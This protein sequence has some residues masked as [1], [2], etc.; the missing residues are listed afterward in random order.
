MK[1]IVGSGCW[2][3]CAAVVAADL[4]ADFITIFAVNRAT[5]KGRGFYFSPSP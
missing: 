5:A 1:I 2:A 3:G 4:Q